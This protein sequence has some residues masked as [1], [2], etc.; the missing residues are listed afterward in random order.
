MLYDDGASGG[1]HFRVYPRF[2]GGDD[3]AARLPFEFQCGTGTVA[4]A[5][6]LLHYGELPF[7]VAEGEAIFEWGNPSNT[8][9]P[10]GIRTSAVRIGVADG[11][12]RRISFSHSVVEIIAE[13]KLSVPEAIR[14]SKC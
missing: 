7:D 4:V 12:I 13:G 11:R 3:S 8:R 14:M 5:L 1:G 2:L 10:Y 9:D 6:A